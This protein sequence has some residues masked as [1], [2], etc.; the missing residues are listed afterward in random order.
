MNP[1]SQPNR[2]IQAALA[3]TSST[4]PF[5]P[6]RVAA[7]AHV[8]FH[9]LQ[10]AEG[11][12]GALGRWAWSS[13]LKG[14]A[15]AAPPALRLALEPLL[16]SP[17][18]QHGAALS[19]TPLLPDQAAQ[20]NGMVPLL[21]QW[22]QTG[23][24]TTTQSVYIQSLELILEDALT[25]T[26]TPEIQNW[27]R[28]MLETLRQ[29]GAHQDLGTLR[30]RLLEPPSPTN[31]N[32]FCQILVH[33]SYLVPQLTPPPLA[34]PAI[35][36]LQILIATIPAPPAPPAPDYSDQ[37]ITALTNKATQYLSAITAI[38][39]ANYFLGLSNE[40]I[41]AV[42]RSCSADT[43][44]S[45]EEAA[46]TA[47]FTAIRESQNSSLKK[48][49]AR[50]IFSVAI[51]GSHFFIGR[52]LSRSIDKIQEGAR[53]AQDNPMKIAEIHNGIIQEINAFLRTLSGAQNKLLLHPE[54]RVDLLE[55]QM[56]KAL[57]SPK[58][59]KGFTQD[60]LFREAVD[61]A[62]GILP[63]L[64]LTEKAEALVSARH[65]AI[66]GLFY[67]AVYYPIIYPVEAVADY[68]IRKTLQFVAIQSTILEVGVNQ[69]GTQVG[70]TS[71]EHSMNKILHE[72]LVSIYQNLQEPSHAANPQQAPPFANKEA[73]RQLVMNVF[74]VLDL[75]RQLRASNSQDNG[76]RQIEQNLKHLAIES[77]APMIGLILGKEMR[78]LLDPNNINM[79]LHLVLTSINQALITPQATL[80]T[81]NEKALLEKEIQKMG[82]LILNKALGTILHEQLAGSSLEPQQ[83][84]EEYRANLQRI[85]TAHHSILRANLDA[86]P[87]QFPGNLR[88]YAQEILLL[89]QKAQDHRTSTMLAPVFDMHYMQTVIDQITALYAAAPAGRQALLTRLEALAH[90][91]PVPTVIDTTPLKPL[92]TSCAGPIQKIGYEVGLDLV[93]QAW[94]LSKQPYVWRYGVIY[95][96]LI[97]FIQNT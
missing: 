85:M 59:N 62:I 47:F 19:E 49:G 1:P 61:K 72:Q 13:A 45:V 42:I 78:A 79:G 71:Y 48:I 9:P 64:G 68:A 55:E 54:D 43:A 81:F 35:T 89:Q 34:E 21:H 95:R 15:S 94:S 73:L 23:I 29:P 87:D 6:N 80:P 46:R 57:S 12:F 24:T 44:A 26:N 93:D 32:S 41:N 11:A 60:R 92:I 10:T 96:T 25:K 86:D 7:V 75:N 97:A 5:I 3:N 33:G 83:L 17:N 37:S 36:R 74:T 65:W 39:A 76:I 63:P 38:H 82:E 52:F 58:Y 84:C 91:L 31:P 22:L 90:N 56:D 67:T 2:I 18:P 50:W 20:G 28:G 8:L 70:L 40:N 30:T 69:F 14:A 27:L 51:W 16:A 88:K 4:P 66:K 53:A 77:T